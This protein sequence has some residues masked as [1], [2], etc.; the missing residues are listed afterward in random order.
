VLVV[1]FVGGN[2]LW[3]ETTAS[4]EYQVKAAFLLRFIPFVEWPAHV[5]GDP[6]A[7]IQIGIL[8]ED[9]FGAVLDQ[10]VTN[11]RIRNRPLIVTRAKNIDDLVDCHLI[12]V[13]DSEIK[14]LNEVTNHFSMSSILTISDLDGFAEHG[15]IIRFYLENKK[16]RFEINPHAAQRQHLKLSAQLL[17]LGTIV[18][19]LNQP[20]VP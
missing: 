5:F 12:Y 20:R 13:C 14:R 18:A 11:Q 2:G 1:L 10:M 16:I 19:D 8:G 3:A 6:E 7:P 17:N 9:P 15:G 4:K